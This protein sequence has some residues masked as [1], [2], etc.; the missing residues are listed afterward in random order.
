MS[1]EELDR[2]IQL[3][4]DA[5]PQLAGPEQAATLERLAQQH[6][7]FLAALEQSLAQAEL[8]EGC[9]RLCAALASYCW[10]RGHAGDGR[11]WLAQALQDATVA[12]ELYARARHAAGTLA[13]AQSDFPDAVRY[14]EAALA[15]HQEQGDEL[16]A[17]RLR[18]RLGTVYRE[19]GRH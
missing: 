15:A 4:E 18:D 11:R 8:C 16:A 7:N 13:F 1:R 2:L 6:D 9:L 19:Q 17:A 12:A 3:A 5:E 10:M 14:F